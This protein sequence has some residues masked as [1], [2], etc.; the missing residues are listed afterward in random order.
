MLKVQIMCVCVRLFYGVSLTGV[1]WV[2]DQHW[3]SW[4]LRCQPVEKKKNKDRWRV[5]DGMQE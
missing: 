1:H 5:S 2:V 3:M 4:S